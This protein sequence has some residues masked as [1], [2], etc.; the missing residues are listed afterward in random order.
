MISP[1]TLTRLIASGIGG[2]YPLSSII[3]SEFATTRW[4]G[5]M[6]GS[7]FA[8]Q[9]VG[10]FAAACVTLIAT[11]GF[12]ASLEGAKSVDKCHGPCNLAVDKMWRIVIGF[13]AIPGCLAL[14]YRLTIPET[15]SLHLRRRPRRNASWFGYQGLPSWSPTRC[16]RRHHACSS[17][18]E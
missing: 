2:D 16:A 14:Y 17:T 12:K 9:G 11:Q 8:M 1:I 4:R 15:S 13:G 10:Q 7:V 3:T 5:A 18:C 6:M